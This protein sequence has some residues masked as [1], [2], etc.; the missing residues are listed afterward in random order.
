MLPSKFPIFII[1]GNFNN[2]RNKSLLKK[3]LQNEY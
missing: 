3:I 1:Q 2:R